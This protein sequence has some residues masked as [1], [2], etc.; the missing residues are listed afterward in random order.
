MRLGNIIEDEYSII[1]RMNKQILQH[2]QVT[3]TH[4]QLK[5]HFIG[6]GEAVHLLLHAN[7][8]M[9]NGEVYVLDMGPPVSISELARQLLSLANSAMGFNFRN[10]NGIKYTGLKPGEKLIEESLIADNAEGTCHPHILKAVEWCNLDNLSATLH[11]LYVACAQLNIPNIISI[12]ESAELG[13]KSKTSP[14][15]TL[16]LREKYNEVKKEREK[17]RLR[18]V[19]STLKESEPI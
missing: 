9:E 11:E 5:Q 19:P 12:L 15:D 8:N 17:T 7:K 2:G 1:A 14:Q 16:W 4:P 13:Y 3:I 18:S 10:L 6:L